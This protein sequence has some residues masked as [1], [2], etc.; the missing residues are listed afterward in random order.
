M[1]EFRKQPDGTFQEWRQ[2]VRNLPQARLE[3]V[4]E[5][6]RRELTAAQAI[7]DMPPLRARMAHRIL[8]KVQQPGDAWQWFPAAMQTYCAELQADVEA[9]QAVLAGG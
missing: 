1:R 4:L 3:E 6:V 8:N 9:I 2:R 7:A 5:D